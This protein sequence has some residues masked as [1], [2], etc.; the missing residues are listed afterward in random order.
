MTRTGGDRCNKE[1]H[2][3]LGLANASTSLE[4]P[5]LVTAVFAV[6]PKCGACVLATIAAVRGEDFAAESLH[7]VL[8]ERGYEPKRCLPILAEQLSVAAGDKLKGALR[9]VNRSVSPAES[10]RSIRSTCTY[11]RKRTRL[12]P[13]YIAEWARA[14]PRGLR[15]GPFPRFADRHCVY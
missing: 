4:A 1:D 7:L 12:A 8:S 13:L 9:R 5:A 10:M 15:L 11:P 3:L 14:V 6:R 2:A